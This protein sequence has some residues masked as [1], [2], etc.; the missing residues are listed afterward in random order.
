MNQSDYLD[1]SSFYQYLGQSSIT[2]GS[3]SRLVT[4]K[5]KMIEF[6]QE[7]KARREELHRDEERQRTKKY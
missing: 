4:Q 3:C 7:D 5:N 6:Y 2:Q 1:Q